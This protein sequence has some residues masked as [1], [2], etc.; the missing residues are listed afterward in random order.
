MV[1]KNSCKRRRR[2]GRPVSHDERSDRYASRAAPVGNFRPCISLG[3]G[4]T[5]LCMSMRSP[6]PLS[7]ATSP[8]RSP[9][10]FH[11]AVRRVLRPLFVAF[12]VCLVA[13]S[14]ATLRR[15]SVAILRRRRP[16]NGKVLRPRLTATSLG[17]AA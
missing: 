11:S 2:S 13:F 8:S 3:G 17:E 1:L 7:V 12:S 9:S 5:R 4:H 15:F 16:Y 6:S 10:K 14:V